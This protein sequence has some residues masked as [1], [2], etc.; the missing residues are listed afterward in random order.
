MSFTFTK[1]KIPDVILIEPTADDSFIDRFHRTIDVML[2]YRSDG[3]V[4]STA[5][6]QA[7]MYGIPVISHVTD[8]YNGQMETIGKAGG[9]A[10]D[11]NEYISFAEQL[12][13]NRKLRMALSQKAKKQH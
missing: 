4:H 3:E 10:R 8:Q 7:M 12:I 5:I 1:L 11:L 13:V 6:A 9:V 2:H